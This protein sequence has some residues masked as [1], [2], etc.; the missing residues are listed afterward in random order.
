MSHSNTILSQL[1][2]FVPRHEFESLAK[3]H[4]SGR[5]C[6]SASRW[7]QFVCLATAQLS[8]RNSLRDIVENMCSG[9]IPLD[10][11]LRDNISQLMRCHNDSKKNV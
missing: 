11:E 1:L 9:L 4:H 10:T 2:K 3:S 6:R 5:A 8:G 7:S